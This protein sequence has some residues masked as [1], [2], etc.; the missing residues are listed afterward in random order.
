MAVIN[1]TDK[2]IYLMEPH[3][4]SRAVMKMLKEH[5]GGSQVGH[6]HVG[7]AELTNWR[8]QHV[9][10]RTIKAYDILCT[11]RNPFDVLVTRWRVGQGRHQ[12][13]LEWGWQNR[14]HIAVGFPLRG[15]YT[16]ANSI[17]YYEDLE[18]DIR[19]CFGLLESEK[20]QD[21]VRLPY[22]QGHKTRGKEGWADMYYKDDF[23]LFEYLMKNKYGAFCR[24]YGYEIEPQHKSL[25]CSIESQNSHIIRRKLTRRIK[26]VRGNEES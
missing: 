20:A 16:D 1:P 12:S 24:R 4:A 7:I 3:T 21:G 13:F 2:W 8:R 17:C 26:R 9:D 19:W 6:H 22:N 15:L 18:D 23:K 10:P 11:V 25:T 14:E 5:L